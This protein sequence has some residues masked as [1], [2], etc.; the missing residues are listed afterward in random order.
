MGE[1]AGPGEAGVHKAGSVC[2]KMCVHPQEGVL[3]NPGR[4]VN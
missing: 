3:S 1:G 2:S 4:D